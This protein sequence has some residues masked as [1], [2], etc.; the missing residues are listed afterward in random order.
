MWRPWLVVRYE[1]KAAALQRHTTNVGLGHTSLR[2][3]TGVGGEYTPAHQE[4]AEPNDPTGRWQRLTHS[5][6]RT[7][8]I[9]SCRAVNSPSRCASLLAC[10]PASALAAA[11]AAS[12]SDT[13]ACSA[14]ASA[15]ADSSDSSSAAAC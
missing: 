11:S 5:P 9:I 7:S 4:A 2:V 6:G 1:H 13:R 12:A 14:A 15:R 8:P 10:A 3:M